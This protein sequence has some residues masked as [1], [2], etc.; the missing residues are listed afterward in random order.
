MNVKKYLFAAV[1]MAVLLRGVV[2]FM[3]YPNTGIITSSDQSGYLS[4]A[5]YYA[6]NHDFDAGF[7]STRMPLFPLFTYLCRTLSENPFFQLIVQNILG[8]SILFIAYRTGRI[9]SAPVALLSMIF[10]AVNLNFVVESNLI[11]TESIFYPVMAAFILMLFRYSMEKNAFN[12]IFCGLLLGLC[13]MIRPIT[14]YMPPFVILFLIAFTRGIPFRSKMIHSLFFLLAFGV[15][16]TP[17]I[18]RN[19]TVFDHAKLTSQGEAHIVGWVVPGIMQ[20][21]EKIDLKKAQKKTGKM[22]QMKKDTLSEKVKSDPF[23]LDKEAKN[24]GVEYILNASPLS[25]AKAWC[26]GAA[27]NVLSPVT[28]ELSYMLDFERSLFHETPGKS[29]PEQLFNFIFRNKSKLYS[30]MMVLGIL[31]ILIFRVV[32]LYGAWKLFRQFPEIF[33]ACSIIII[34]FLLISGPVG[35]AK[36]RIPFESILVFLGAFAFYKRP[37]A[38]VQAG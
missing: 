23:L 20:Y 12:I 18:F 38:K 9:F 16:I 3:I 36:Y 19:Y 33:A 13:T 17:W 29:P 14:F 10:A 11:L 15:V 37:Q 34:Y 30:L 32:Q 8:L 1:V 28:V 25:I 6:E 31:G 22:W 21:E 26:W 27:R 5:A 24:F 2:F 7:G 35:Y 4:L